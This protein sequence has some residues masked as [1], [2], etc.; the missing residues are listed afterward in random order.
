M[1]EL[2]LKLK[3]PAISCGEFPIVKE[4]VYFLFARIPSRKQREM[5][6]L[7]NSTFDLT[8]LA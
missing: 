8:S 3:F 7:F 5:R 4:N 6:A 2:V 1:P